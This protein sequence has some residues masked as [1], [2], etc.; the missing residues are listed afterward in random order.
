MSTS[1]APPNLPFT[2]RIL[3]ADLEALEE[4]LLEQ[5]ARQ[6]E[7]IDERAR[8]MQTELLRGFRS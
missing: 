3:K 7:Y 1:N 2:R 8:D 5:F 4:R 6:R